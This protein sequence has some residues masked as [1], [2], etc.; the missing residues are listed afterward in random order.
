LATSENRLAARINHWVGWTSGLTLAALLAKEGYEL[1]AQPTAEGIIVVFAIVAVA[2]SVIRDGLHIKQ[3]KEPIRVLRG[4]FVELALL[5][6]IVL[7]WGRPDIWAL[8]VFIRQS[9]VLVKLAART[10]RYRRFMERIQAT[11]A[12][13]LVLSFLLVIVAGSLLLTFPRATTDGRGA[14]A[15]DAIFTSTSATCV[16]GLSTLNTVED[17]HEDKSRRTFTRFGQFVILILIQIGGLGI[18]TLSAATVMFAGRRL[19]MRKRAMMQSIMDEG[20]AAALR[21]TIRDILLMTFIIEGVGAIFLIGRFL[22]LDYPLGEAIWIGTFHSV[23]AFCNAG[24]SLFGDSLASFKGDVVINLVHAILIMLGG[25]GFVVITALFAGNTW[26]RG[27]SSGWRRLSLQIRLV[28][29][30]SVAL[31][32]AGTIFYFFLEYDHSLKGLSV[33]EKLIASFF[34][35]VSFRTAGF[36]TVDMGVM[37]RAMILVAC[38]LMFIGASPG[39]TGGGVKTTTISV[40]F[41]SIRASLLGRRDVEIGKHSINPEVVTRAISIVAIAF[42]CLLLGVILLVVTQPHIPFESLIF[43]A[44]SALGTVGLTLGATSELNSVGKGIILVL[45]FVGRL[46]PLTVALA[47]GERRKS[48]GFRYSEERVIVG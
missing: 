11:P 36:N 48:H 4:V 17:E 22:T 7:T 41:M 6:P 13:T 47:V 44:V 9:I 43:E 30:V 8:M 19:D 1:I 18:M 37:S 33:G 25:V 42:S 23:S 38:V 34:Q 3:S 20:S 35:S 28:V 14:A 12:K 5:V 32:V 26:K 46:G 31:V 27:V 29:G 39:S 45:M 40:L 24:F 2:L 16:T 21:K 10:A 15:I